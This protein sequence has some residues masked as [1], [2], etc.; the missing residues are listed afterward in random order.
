MKRLKLISISIASAVIVVII[1]V[2]FLFTTTVRGNNLTAAAEIVAAAEGKWTYKVVNITIG[3]DTE[4]P[5]KQFNIL[6]A[7]GWELV[8]WRSNIVIFKKKL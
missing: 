1:G 2:W 7:Q 3:T 8:N 6:G 4:G 5:Q